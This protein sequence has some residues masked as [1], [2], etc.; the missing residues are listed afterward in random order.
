M[1]LKIVTRHMATI[2]VL[3]LLLLGIFSAGCTIVYDEEEKQ[4]NPSGDGE[5]EIYF[6]DGKFDPIGYVDKIWEKKVLPY[7]AAEAADLADLLN[8]L[9][10]DPQA[11]GEECGHREKAEGSPW[12]FIVKGKGRIVEVNTRSRAS[13][14]GVDLDPPDGK[15]DA[16][17]QI[18]PVLKG[19]GIRDSLDF[20]SFDD[21]V[22]QLEF[23]R[24]SNAMNKRIN[25]TIL[26]SLDRDNLMGKPVAFTGVFTL[27]NGP[28]NIRIT[29]TVFQI[30]EDPGK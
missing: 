16:L 10:T 9:K 25:D 22:N 5:L 3:G 12:N 15:R 1:D 7:M 26:S 4:S 8:A 17:V 23:A 21:F 2:V 24:L 29:P 20:I 6:V 28:E 27:N 11:A 18:G 13:T 19:T 14:V 30:E